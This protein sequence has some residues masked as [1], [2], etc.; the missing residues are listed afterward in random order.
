MRVLLALMVTGLF[1]GSAL[2]GPPASGLFAPSDG[3]FSEAWYGPD[4]RDGEIGNTIHAASWNGTDLGAEWVVSCTSIA[5]D[6]ELVSNTI[7]GNG[8]GE[9]TYRTVYQNGTVW[10]SGSG[11]WGD[12]SQDYI[13]DIYSFVVVATYQFGPGGVLIGIRSNVTMEAAIRG[14][15]DC[16]EYSINNAAI[17]ANTDGEPFPAGYPAFLD[18][19]DCMTGVLNQGAWGTATE[20]SLYIYGDCTVPV[21]ETSWGHIKSLY[22]E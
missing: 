11:P 6:P 19:D 18:P 22:S 3:L 2:A 1:A 9:V 5:L 20:V 4:Y 7:G 10:L 21:K 13:A 12:V 15:D 16:L 14:F 8:A 17:E